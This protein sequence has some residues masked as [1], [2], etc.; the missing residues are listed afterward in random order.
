MP[1]LNASLTGMATIWKAII[2]CSVVRTYCQRHVIS[3]HI[4]GGRSVT[5]IIWPT[6][7]ENMQKIYT[8]ANVASPLCAGLVAAF[9]ILVRTL[10]STASPKAAYPVAAHSRNTQYAYMYETMMAFFMPRTGHGSL[11]RDA[12]SSGWNALAPKVKATADRPRNTPGDCCGW[13][14]HNGSPEISVDR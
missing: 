10:P 1:V 8:W 12:W 13:L 11:L 14:R 9:L 4:Y 3:R 5:L 7:A 6:K 2:T